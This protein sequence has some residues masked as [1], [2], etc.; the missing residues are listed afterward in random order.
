MKSAKEYN[1]Q[2]GLALLLIGS[3]KSGKTALAMT[4]PRP[5]ILDCDNN[6]RGALKHHA[7]LGSPITEYY[8]DNPGEVSPEKRWEFSM[9]KLDEAIASPDIDTII[10]DGLTLLGDYL[11]AFILNNTRSDSSQSHL[12]I[13]GQKCM[14]M[15]HW[16][17][18]KNLMTKL[19]MAGKSSGKMFIMTCHESAESDTNGSIIAYRPLIQGS[20]KNN[21]AGFFSDCWRTESKA[22][23]AKASEYKVRF[24]P[25]NLFQIGNSLAIKDIDLDTTNLTREQIWSKLESYIK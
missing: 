4:F 23:H 22:N 20:L 19:V 25:K 21:I 11:Q 14:Q 18:F 15:N 9:Q 24:A 16:T 13:A 3:P 8:Y 6:L 12:I 7:S 2:G 5:Y 10:V 1:A 17:P